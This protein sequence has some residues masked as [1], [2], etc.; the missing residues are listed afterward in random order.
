MS[1]SS[2]LHAAHEVEAGPLLPSRRRQQNPSSSATATTGS[3]SKSSSRCRKWWGT[4]S[5]SS[6]SGSFRRSVFMVIVT[7]AVFVSVVGFFLGS[8]NNDFATLLV[9]GPWRIVG[10]NHNAGDPARPMMDEGAG[11][12]VADVNS[13]QSAAANQRGG[14]GG[15]GRNGVAGEAANNYTKPLLVFHGAFIIIFGFFWHAVVCL[16]I[17]LFPTGLP[18]IISWKSRAAVQ[19][20]F[21]RDRQ[22]RHHFASEQV[23]RTSQRSVQEHFLR[24]RRS[25]RRS[26][27]LYK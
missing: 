6:P 20:I 2:S 8:D 26:R 17:F 24:L 11:A 13:S 21:S 12:S 22:D 18:H 14:G 25:V 3:S 23:F 7:A 10:N 27:P 19:N 1:S 5:S 9:G 15:G 4:L 16:L